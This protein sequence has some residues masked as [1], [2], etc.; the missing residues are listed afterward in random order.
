MEFV[1]DETTAH[2]GALTDVAQAQADETNL[3]MAVVNKDMTAFKALINVVNPNMKTSRGQSLLHVVCMETTEMHI[4]QELLRVGADPNVFDL[5]NST[6]L[7]YACKTNQPRAVQTLLDYGAAV[8]ESDD[9]NMTALMM[10]ASRN[11]AE[12]ISLLLERDATGVNMADSNG[13]TALHW[14]VR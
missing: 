12:V 13:Y 8:N 7:M 9:R 1:K 5:Q 14:A 10:A 4:L 6:P 11:A 2:N 3:L